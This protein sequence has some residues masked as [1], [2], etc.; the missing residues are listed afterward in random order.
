MGIVAG[1]LIAGAPAVALLMQGSA[2]QAQNTDLQHRLAG[3][4]QQI[5][6]DSNALADLTRQVS[7]LESQAQNLSSELA[8]I[9]GVIDF[10]DVRTIAQGNLTLG[11]NTGQGFFVGGPDA[12]MTKPGYVAVI[13]RGGSLFGGSIDAP[14]TVRFINK[15]V[16]WAIVRAAQSVPVTYSPPMGGYAN[17]TN[18]G[19]ASIWVDFGILYLT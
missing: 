3:A 18:Y 10:T 15:S 7:F 13:F 8:V 19:S 2:L 12:N 17:F 14:M 9:H 4:Q 5:A 16:D 11:K 6:N 1:L